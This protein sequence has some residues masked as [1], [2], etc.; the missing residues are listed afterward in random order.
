MLLRKQNAV[1]LV[2]CPEHFPIWGLCDLSY[3]FV[4]VTKLMSGWELVVVDLNRICTGA[5]GYIGKKSKL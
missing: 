4:S 1:G 3:S 2:L 5:G